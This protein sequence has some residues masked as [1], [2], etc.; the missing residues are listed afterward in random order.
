MPG[1]P[2]KP[3]PTSPGAAR[4]PISPQDSAL[5]TIDM[6]E[7]LRKMA[8]RQGHGVLAHLL[9]LAQAEARMLTRASKS[10]G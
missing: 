4:G 8:D 7:G 3:E 6:L 1:I 9:E 10:R 5:Y 2:Q